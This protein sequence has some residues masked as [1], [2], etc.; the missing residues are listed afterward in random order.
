MR[1][2]PTT[3]AYVERRTK[4]G[5][6]KEEILRCLKYLVRE[7]HTALLADFTALNRLLSCRMTEAAL[8]RRTAGHARRRGLRVPRTTLTV[9]S[10]DDSAD[11]RRARVAPAAPVRPDRSRPAVD[12]RP[13]TST[14]RSAVAR[15]YA[16]GVG[17]DCAV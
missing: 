2:D 1:Y 9:S 8:R 12:I 17:V 16:R 14:V 5:L 13:G 6:S 11:R 7:V 4:Q 15:T 10:T 3:Q